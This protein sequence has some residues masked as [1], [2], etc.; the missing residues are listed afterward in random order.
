MRGNAAGALRAYGTCSAARAA[1]AEGE[2]PVFARVSKI[3]PGMAVPGMSP[4]SMNSGTAPSA[5]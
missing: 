2:K 5:M 3:I 4:E 1:P